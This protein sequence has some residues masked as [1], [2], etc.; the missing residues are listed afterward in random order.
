MLESFL[1]FE[2]QDHKL[3]RNYAQ[4][5]KKISSLVLENTKVNNV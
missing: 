5:K 4:N 3:R 2:K 1:I